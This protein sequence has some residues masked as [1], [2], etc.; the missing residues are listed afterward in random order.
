MVILVP[1]DATEH[2]LYRQISHR[3]HPAFTNNPHSFRGL[4]D[5]SGF[6]GLDRQANA[7]RRSLDIA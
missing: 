4:Q 7:L 2:A 6:G 5:L 3:Q 1:Q